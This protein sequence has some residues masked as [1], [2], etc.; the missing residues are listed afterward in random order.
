MGLL[1]SRHVVG[2]AD[3]TC[4]LMYI[5]RQ[6]AVFDPHSTDLDQRMFCVTQAHTCPR[7]D[8]C[9]H[10]PPL[11][12]KYPGQSTRQVVFLA[13]LVEVVQGRCR[14]SH[15]E[16]QCAVPA[17][18]FTT[19]RGCTSHQVTHTGQDTYGRIYHDYE[20]SQ[21]AQEMSAF[22]KSIYCM[23][24]VDYR[25]PEKYLVLFSQKKTWHELGF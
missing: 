24:M 23:V 17:V 5:N 2:C 20:Q 8:E 13:Q 1:M 11:H 3:N 6:G 25:K 22:L 14:R 7:S 16:R 9:S 21:L 15:P 12:G 4:E 19:E 10:T 18:L